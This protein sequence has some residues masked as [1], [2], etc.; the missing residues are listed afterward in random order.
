MRAAY[1][2]PARRYA[3]VVDAQAQHNDAAKTGGCA[4]R[5]DQLPGL[6][7]V[8][9]SASSFVAIAFET[10]AAAEDAL[11]AVRELDAAHEIS[12]RDAAVVVR[13]E[14][15]R[16]ELYQ[17]R[18]IAAGE[19]LV[20][21]GTVGLVAGLLLGLPVG[22]ALLGLAGGALF[23]LRDTGIPDGRLR[24]LGADLQPGQ[25]LLC[26]LVDADRV[27]RTREALGCYGT[28]VE[29]ELSPGSDP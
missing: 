14:S 5:Q 2:S 22:G 6:I 16:I 8:P 4:R 12:L 11:P 26:V 24:E 28:V 23:G 7:V 20:G 19:G 17:T 18:E 21:G 25:A 10:A 1:A 29:V 3:A 15:G 9:S 27:L 13:T